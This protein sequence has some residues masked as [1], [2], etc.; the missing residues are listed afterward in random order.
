MS[1]RL[2][3]LAGACVL[4]FAGVARAAGPTG[5]GN[6]PPSDSPPTPPACSTGETHPLP[7]RLW[8]VSCSEKPGSTICTT[9]S[10]SGAPD[11][12]VRKLALRLPRSF[13]AITLTCSE[14]TGRIACR[15]VN[16]RTVT[17]DGTR[18]VVLRLP[19]YFT[20]VRV[21]C[22]TSPSS[23]FGCRLDQQPSLRVRS[24]APFTVRGTHFQPF[25]SVRLTF[26]GTRVAHGK[27][28]ANGAFVVTFRGVDVDP[29]N[30]YAVKAVGAKGSVAALRAPPRECASRN[31]G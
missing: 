26:A 11:A 30:G 14:Q 21:A 17:A 13:V 18:T 4:G 3:V 15:I 1:R 2:A 10:V 29:C 19:A 9:T 25:E 12:A 23:G 5:G 6:P 24:L 16:E 31:P 22:G 7:C 27:A 28:D 8:T 20:A